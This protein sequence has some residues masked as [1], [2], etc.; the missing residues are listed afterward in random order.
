MS[1]DIKLDVEEMEKA[2]VNFGH[3]V[4]KLH[5]KMKPYVSGMKNGVHIFDLV[6]IIESWRYSTRTFSPIEKPHI[7]S[8]MWFAI[9]S[10]GAVGR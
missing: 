2:G 4:S 6:I 9:I 1:K 8:N 10:F 7:F 5:P 3:K